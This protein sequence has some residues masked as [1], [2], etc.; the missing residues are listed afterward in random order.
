MDG[1]WGHG[2]SWHCQ[3]YINRSDS[4]LI[5]EV[6]FLWFFW[7]RVSV[8]RARSG[9]WR[10]CCVLQVSLG[11]TVVRRWSSG[12]FLVVRQCSSAL[13]PAQTQTYKR[14]LS[15]VPAPTTLAQHWAYVC[16]AEPARPENRAIV[17]IWGEGLPG[18][19]MSWDWS[20]R[21][22][23]LSGHI[24]NYI[25]W[26]KPPFPRSASAGSQCQRPTSWEIK[27]SLGE[28]ALP[29]E[30][31]GRER[32]IGLIPADSSPVLETLGQGYQD[33]RRL[34]SLVCCLHQVGQR[35]PEHQH[36]DL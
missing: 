22:D 19:A 20:L 28:V 36:S 18:K 34:R 16:A 11:V 17:S 3:L 23:R 5:N 1:F 4:Y 32:Q 21:R 35:N 13:V 26:W 6:S 24:L 31:M 27:V 25:S 8:D 29:R 10:A 9:G 7:R 14:R 12:G 33:E 15:A 2:V 30:G